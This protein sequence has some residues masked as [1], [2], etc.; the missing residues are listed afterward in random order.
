MSADSSGLLTTRG[1]VARRPQPLAA[2]VLGLALVGRPWPLAA[3]VIGLAI[4]RRPRVG[5]LRGVA[6]VLGVVVAADSV[7]CPLFAY[8]F[9]AG[10][11]PSPTTL[12][13]TR[14]TWLCS[15]LPIG[16]IFNS[17]K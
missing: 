4:A 6:L 12:C 2:V 16:S 5:V 11:P 15:R 13:K 8:P 17:A 1:V 9:A 10:S 7:S 3:L 14:W